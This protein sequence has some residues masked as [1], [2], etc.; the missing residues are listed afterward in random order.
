MLI[1]CPGGPP[2]CGYAII[3]AAVD[4]ASN[5]DSIHVLIQPEHKEV[6]ILYDNNVTLF[7]DSAEAT[8]I[9]AA[10]S[11]S[12]TPTGLSAFPQVRK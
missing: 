4:A 7:W 12:T 5:G 10:I 6:G 1:V 9:Q 8:V 11:T 3:Q 2:D